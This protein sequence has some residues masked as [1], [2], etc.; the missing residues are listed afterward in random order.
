M[1]EWLSTKEEPVVL[2][3][4][5]LSQSSSLKEGLAIKFITL[6]LT[7]TKFFCHQWHQ[8]WAITHLVEVVKTISGAINHLDQSRKEFKCIQCS[9]LRNIPWVFRASE[10][11]VKT[12]I[13]LP[14]ARWTAE[15]PWKIGAY[16][17]METILA[18]IRSPKHSHRHRF[19][20][21][22]RTKVEPEKG[23]FTT[24]QEMERETILELGLS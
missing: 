16:S 13:M 9:R 24:I 10:M 12:R 8:I 23:V 15:G 3:S 6:A 22:L 5:P 2:W 17:F 4:Q 14:L 11:E 19:S 1:V 7:T 18:S 20:W 21:C